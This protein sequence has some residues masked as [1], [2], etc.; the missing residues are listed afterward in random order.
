MAVENFRDIVPVFLPEEF[1]VGR[2]EGRAIFESLVGG[3]R[4]RASITA[5]ST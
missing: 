3:L 1:F 5:V 2:L 4:K